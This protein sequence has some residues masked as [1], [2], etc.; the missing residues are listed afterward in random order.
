MHFLSIA[1]L[2]SERSF[3]LCSI[4]PSTH[5]AIWPEIELNVK[6][7]SYFIYFICSWI[8]ENLTNAMHLFWKVMLC[9]L[10]YFGKD[11]RASSEHG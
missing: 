10:I 4:F 1:H 3:E 2:N 11:R 8:S 7:A 6:R 9:S 5:S